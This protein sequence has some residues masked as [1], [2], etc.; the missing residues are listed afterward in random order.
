MGLFKEDL[1]PIT[2]G[3]TLLLNLAQVSGSLSMTENYL[4]CKMPLLLFSSL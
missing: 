3:H 4:S 1:D 2:C